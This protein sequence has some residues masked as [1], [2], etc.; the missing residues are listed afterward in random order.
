LHAYV[1]L[2][3]PAYLAASVASYLPVVDRVIVSFDRRH[4][5][6]SGETVPV[7]ECLAELA[8]L[9][10]EGK[11]EFRAGDFARPDAPP[12]ESDTRQRQVALDQ[13][14]D[15][16]DWVLQLD[17]DEVVPAPERLRELVVRAR[18]AGAVGLDYPS[19]WLYADVGGGRFLEKGTRFWRPAASYPGPLAVRAGVRLRLARQVDGPLYRADFRRSNT[20]PWHP[21]DAA[22]DEV[23]PANEGV[24]HYSWV[25]S[26]AEMT[27]KSRTSG[28]RDDLAWHRLLVEWRRRQRHPRVAV[29][30]T[31]FRRRDP[32]GWLRLVTPP[33]YVEPRAV[34][35]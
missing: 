13:A 14:S 31:P 17:S 10:D 27:R 4:L 5:S 30:G 3:D 32:H 1:L 34:R 35:P 8:G 21:V 7:E 6:W 22:V 24:L 26:D 9:K 25:R 16:A 19:R 11:L 2:A 12:L 28:H 29:A 18:A 23:I 33:L 15:G 20:D